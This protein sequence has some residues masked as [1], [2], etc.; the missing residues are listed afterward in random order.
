MHPVWAGVPP[1]RLC[2][3]LVHSL[4]HLLLF[5]TLLP[6][7]FF[8][9]SST[10][11][12]FSGRELAFTFATCHRDSVCLSVVGDVGAPYS[13]GWTFRQFFSPN[14]SP[15]TLLFQCQKS[16]VG[17]APFP[18]NLRSK[19]PTTFKTAQFR[20]ITAHS[21]STVIASEKSLIITYRKSTT[22]F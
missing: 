3:S 4:P 5:I 20:P 21:V 9:F 18:W 15:G 12:I 14:D 1:F 16:L 8:L 7:P 10:L 13:G 11:L 19:W 22:R 17:D 6:F 2:S